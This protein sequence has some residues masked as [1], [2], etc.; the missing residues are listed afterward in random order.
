M[1]LRPANENSEGADDLRLRELRR[2]IGWIG[3]ILRFGAPL[4][5]VWN[6]AEDLL[7]IGYADFL[8]NF[9]RQIFG[10]AVM[11]PVADWQRLTLFAFSLPYHVAFF[12][13]AYNLWLL[14]SGYLAGRIFTVNAAWL[15]Q[16]CGFSGIA[17]MVCLILG[18]QT[19]VP[20]LAATRPAGTHAVITP[21]YFESNDL[22]MLIFYLALIGL[23]QI[24]K[25]AAEIYIENGQII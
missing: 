4:T 1:P 12:A 10:E 15:I 20:V 8:P 13:L 3:Q 7:L 25:V 9:A 14:F 24:Q 5:F 2:R 23:A 22:H 16:R 6:L 17:S 18:R 21:P 19:I 11:Q